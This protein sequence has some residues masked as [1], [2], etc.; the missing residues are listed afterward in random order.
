MLRFSGHRKRALT[1]KCAVLGLIGLVSSIQGFSRAA[2]GEVSDENQRRL[3]AAYPEHLERIDGNTLIW[4]DGT[5]MTLDDGKGPKPIDAW[6]DD[7]DIEDM[8][9]IPYPAGDTSAR[10]GIAPE[11]PARDIDPGRARNAAL[12]DKLYGDC[13]KGE[14]EKNLTDVIWLKHKKG[15]RVTVTRV[16]GVAEKLAAVSAELDRLPAAF[17]RFL[18]PSEGTYVCRAIAGTNRMS[19][20]GQGIAIDI[21]TKHAHYWRWAAPRTKP[22][23]MP[24]TGLRSGVEGA[25]IVY[26]NEIPMEIV[27]IFEK[28]GFI[29]GGRWY[30]YDTMHFEFRPELLSMESAQVPVP[31]REGPK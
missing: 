8:F 30:H 16:N 28:H 5:R 10:P 4:R 21:S 25:A 24:S 12:F 9:S 14:V 31:A 17:D 3:L 13:R 29:W 1:A 15:Q 27:R 18:S 26:R 20:H 7:P 2:A 23:A 11:P 22:T 19:A 6:L